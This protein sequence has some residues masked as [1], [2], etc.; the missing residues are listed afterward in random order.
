MLPAVLGH[1]IAVLGQVVEYVVW[2]HPY[3]NQST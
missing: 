2:S 3:V 1:G